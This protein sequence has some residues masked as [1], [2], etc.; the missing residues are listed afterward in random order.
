MTDK[1]REYG[2]RKSQSQQNIVK[3]Y[4]IVWV[5]CSHTIQYESTSDTKYEDMS[6]IYNIVWIMKQLKLLCV[7]VDSH[8]NKIYSEF[9]T[10]K[11]SYMIRQQSDETMTKY[12]D[13]LKLARVNAQLSERN[14]TKHE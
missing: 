10:L 2:K 1:H 14:L 11:T 4:G 5:Q 3:L 7:G 6:E 9:H 13:R 12:F 8:I